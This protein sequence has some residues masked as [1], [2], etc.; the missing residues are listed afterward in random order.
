MHA[1]T[2]T[3]MPQRKSRQ[4]ATHLAGRAAIRGSRFVD[5]SI[6]RFVDSSIPDSRLGMSHRRGGTPD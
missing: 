2:A 1:A 4:D 5:S 6:R 3:R